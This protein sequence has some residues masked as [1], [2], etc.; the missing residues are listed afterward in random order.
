MLVSARESWWAIRQDLR[1]S[2]LPTV[3]ILILIIIGTLIGP[4]CLGSEDAWANPQNQASS[5]TQPKIIGAKA[6]VGGK[7]IQLPAGCQ[8][9]VYGMATGGRP[10]SLFAKGQ[11]V[12]VKNAS[13]A[14]VAELSVGT[15]R[16]DR[17][18]TETA[19]H[20]IA[21]FGA[22]DFHFAQGYYAINSG[23]SAKSVELEFT[24]TSPAL[25]AIIGMASSQQYLTLSGLPDFI[26]D[27]PSTRREALSIGHA[28]LG[29][30][31]Y[32]IQEK[33]FTLAVL[34][35]P[36]H[37]ADLLG[38][39]VFADQQPASSSRNQT[40]PIPAFNRSEPE[41]PVQV[42]QL[43]QQTLPNAEVQTPQSQTPALS[44]VDSGIPQ[45]AEQNSNAVALILSISKYQSTDIPEVKYAKDDARVVRQYLTQAMGFKPANVLPSNLGEQLTYGRIQT[46]IKSILPSYLKP[47]GSSDLFIYF[48]GHGAPST[49]NH[50]AYLVPWDCDPNYVNDDNAYDM[51]KFY[52]DIAKLNARHKVIVVDACFSG[53]TGAGQALLKNASPLYLK[54]NNPLIADSNT[55]ILQSSSADQVSNW[56]DEKRHGMFTYFLLKGLQGGADYN[57]DGEITAEELIKYINNQNDGLPYY[58]NRLYQRPQEAQLEGN[59]QMVIEKIRK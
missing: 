22:L 7:Q 57:S 3:P 34:Q 30:G 6:V 29:P 12:F 11:S 53:Q 23:P 52:A 33:S 46:Y 54:V 51:K 4:I 42:Q 31:T 27:V 43:P 20:V 38:V 18:S 59:G 36:A 24:L 1:S 19:Y 5:T 40:I 41:P 55:V 25:V 10:S 13:G 47:D 26:V 58:S 8:L 35:R 14:I 9:Y 2:F 39:L 16:I 50:E 48:T 21:G 37:Q 45:A 15:Q 17:F 49:I 56:Y 32:K 44:E 28:Y